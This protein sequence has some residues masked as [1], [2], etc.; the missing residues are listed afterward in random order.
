LEEQNSQRRDS[1]AHVFS[2]EL[3]S[4]R[5]LSPKVFEVE[6]RRPERLHFK[7]GQ[8]LCFVYRSEERYYSFVSSPDDSTIALCVRHVETGFFSPILASAGIGTPFDVT[9]PHGYF[10]FTPSPRA[11]IF[12]ATGTGVAPF[13]SMA[14]A[15]VKDFTLLHGV[16]DV[17]DLY[18]KNRLAAS[19]KKH[20]PC[21][22]GTSAQTLAPDACFRGRVTEFLMQNLPPAAYDFYLCGRQDMIRDVMHLVDRRF[23]GSLVYYEVFY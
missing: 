22:P 3:L 21:V 17:Q 23:P 9:G 6:L 10:I 15:G 19:A 20:I 7:P 18:Y 16:S 8:T 12:I 1:D 11:P 14:G 4:R 5:W 13:V 2:T